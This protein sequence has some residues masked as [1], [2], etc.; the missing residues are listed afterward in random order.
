MWD[1]AVPLAVVEWMSLARG[2]H[3]GLA[4]LFLLFQYDYVVTVPRQVR[5]IIFMRFTYFA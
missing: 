1:S 5:W 3:V 4:R 2:R